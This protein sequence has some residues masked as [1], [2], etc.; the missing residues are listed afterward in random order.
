[1]DTCRYVEGRIAEY[2]SETADLLEHRYL[3]DSNSRLTGRPA[4]L[5]TCD[6]RLLS[7]SID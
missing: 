7:L 2:W 5:Y 1:M 6:L 4:G 3:A